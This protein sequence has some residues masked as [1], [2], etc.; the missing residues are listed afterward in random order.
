MKV[1]HSA[2]ALLLFIPVDLEAQ[3]DRRRAAGD[4]ADLPTIEVIGPP[5]ALGTIPGSGAI[6]DSVTLAGSRVFTTSEALRKVS[7]V[8][9]REE[10][11]FGL[12]PNIG[13]RGLNPTR[14]TKV[15]LLEDGV[16]F[17]I[18]PYGDNATYYHPPIDRFDRIEVLKGSGQILYGPQ[19]IGGVI[20][21]IT[22][23]IPV[24][25]FAA[26]TLTPGNRG[27]LDGRV[28]AGG[29]WGRA[30]V[31]AEYMRK[32][33][34]G[35]RD[36]VGSKLDDVTLKTRLALGARQSLTLRG[37]YYRERSQ[38]TYSGLTE[39]E[40]AADPYQNPFVND[41]MKLDRWGA[42]A[43]HNAELA[44]GVALMTTAYGYEVARDWW[45][46]SSNSAQRPNDS[47]DPACGGLANLSTGC[48][49]EGRLRDYTVGGIE[50]RLH[51]NYTLGTVAAV[52]DVG[53]RAH[54]ESQERRQVNGASPASREAGPSSN[55]NA[56]LKE[57]NERS[58]QAY[59]AF[60]QQRFV[61]GPLGLV[62]GVRVE[63]VR[64]RRT[65]LLGSDPNGVTGRTSLTQ[66][67][68]GVG[69]T[70]QAGAVTTLFAGVHRG[71]APPRTEDLIDN[72][73]GGVVD[74]DAELSWNYEIGVRTSPLQGLQLEATGFHMDFENQIIPASLAGGSGATL[75]SA[76]QTVH[77]GLE[78]GGRLST[79][80]WLGGKH[81][82]YLQA[83]WTWLPTARFAGERFVYVG[84]GG[85]DEIGKV[86]AAQN[87]AGTREQVSVTGRRLPYAPRHLLTGTVGYAHQ[88]GLDLRLEFVHVARQFGDALNTTVLSADGQ[89]GP[90]PAFTI[91]NLAAS[92]RIR[93]L[94]NTVFVA[95]KNLFDKVYVVDRTRGLLPGSPRLVQAGIAQVF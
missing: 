50:P 17:V 54:F 82:V 28:R 3:D 9:V 36:N 89:Q 67:I 7:G 51:L 76:G 5:A 8:D 25:P 77:R 56:G 30:G 10:E 22:P 47:S 24:R 59:S 63:R 23:A 55:P 86:Y 6:L 90:I 85:S 39:A 29:S 4:T 73:T 44:P 91:G 40:Y 19:T 62:P 78:L 64:Y 66:V 87:S 65:N 69:A 83:A 45:R 41:S 18:A 27:Y 68:P 14:S 48:G 20:N 93:P 34:D 92:W 16:P 75:T 49:N 61:I 52:T 2:A 38:V 95:V 1:P 94:D 74:L 13:I 35:A 11:G 12:R 42:S 81:E 72:S 32:Q 57:N 43:I 84:R 60:A 15:L 26:V 70:Y 79:S 37:N 58:N 31:L 53:V 80:P 71:F 88:A 21:Y 33:G 46:Q